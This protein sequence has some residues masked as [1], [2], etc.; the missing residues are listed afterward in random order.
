LPRKSRVLRFRPLTGL[1]AS[2][3]VAAT[4]GKATTEAP[5]A[6]HCRL[7]Q[8]VVER[9]PR[10]DD[11]LAL[12]MRVSLGRTAGVAAE[13]EKLLGLPEGRL[14][15]EDFAAKEVRACAFGRIGEL[16]SEAA[17][18]FLA[19]LPRGDNRVDMPISLWAAS[20][21]ALQ[22]A[23]LHQVPDGQEKR[24]FLESVLAA[25]HEGAEACGTGR[26]NNCA[27][28]EKRYR[29]VSS[30][31]PSAKCGVVSTARRRLHSVANACR[32]LPGIPSASGP[33]D[34]C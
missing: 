6:G 15:E 17:V 4:V 8:R 25:P 22:N 21:I 10:P 1:L 7:L 31:G 24:L 14:K 33:S 29:P 28:A 23:R 9:S 32:L 5:Y 2:V 27:T 13:L 12:L 20:R 18:Q 30:S 3:V 11:A 34:H 26:L 16:R 19:N